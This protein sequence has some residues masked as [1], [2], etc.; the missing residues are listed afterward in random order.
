MKKIKKTLLRLCIAILLVA[1]ATS[2]TWWPLVFRKTYIQELS[3]MTLPASARIIEYRYVFVSCRMHHFFSKV[4]ISYYDIVSLLDVLII[5]PEYI[6]E[7]LIDVRPLPFF[8]LFNL[9]N[10]EILW[11]N[12]LMRRGEMGRTR[13]VYVFIVREDSGR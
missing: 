4:E 9:E 5:R 10:A 13:N 8:H 6:D 1:L 2:V 11:V 7:L 12:H 3:R